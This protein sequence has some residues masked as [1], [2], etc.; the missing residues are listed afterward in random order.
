[1]YWAVSAG[2]CSC[3]KWERSSETVGK[4]LG[5]I[6]QRQK[7]VGVKAVDIVAVGGGG[8]VDKWREIGKKKDYGEE[9]EVI[10]RRPGTR[11][12]TGAEG[13]K[14]DKT[15]CRNGRWRGRQDDDDCR[16][17]RSPVD[18]ERSRR[19]PGV[20]AFGACCGPA[21]RVAEM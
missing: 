6:P 21:R 12:E 15:R 14:E 2:T 10:R 18:R 17:A 3:T 11:S 4:D 20:Y 13:R 16:I 9:Q 1:M 19:V 8:A 7:K 5:Q